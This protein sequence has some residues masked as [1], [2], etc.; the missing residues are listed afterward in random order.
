[1][2]GLADPP[3]PSGGVGDDHSQPKP[4]CGLPAARGVPLRSRPDRVA[5]AGSTPPE[6]LDVSMPAAA[7]VSPSWVRTMRVSPRRATVRLVSEVISSA[8]RDAGSMRPSAL[9]MILD[10]T[11][12]MSPSRSGPGGLPPAPRGSRLQD[13]CRLRPPRSRRGE[14][15]DHGRLLSQHRI[16]RSGSADHD[17]A[18]LI[19]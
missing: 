13:Q 5:A 9:L 14:D 2:V 19:A 1:M 8:R 4:G 18:D 10:V 15:R 17:V 7:M 12:T 6:R 16:V 11:T 3:R